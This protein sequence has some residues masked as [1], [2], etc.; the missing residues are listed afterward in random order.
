M[1]LN[2]LHQV[3]LKV[4]VFLALVNRSDSKTDVAKERRTSVLITVDSSTLE[5]KRGEAFTLLVNHILHPDFQTARRLKEARKFRST[6]LVTPKM[7]KL[8]L[9]ESRIQLEAALRG[10]AKGIYELE[11]SSSVFTCVREVCS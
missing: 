8:E 4:N 9:N 6:S 2:R 7:S 3:V 10:T 11:V 5:E 1:L